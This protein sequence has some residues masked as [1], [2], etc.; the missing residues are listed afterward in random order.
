MA[1]WQKNIHHTKSTT[2]NKS[3]KGEEKTQKRKKMLNEKESF[4]KLYQTSLYKMM[5]KRQQHI[6]THHFMHLSFWILI[7]T[8][9][10]TSNLRNCDFQSVTYYSECA[11]WQDLWVLML[12]FPW[13]IF[14]EKLHID[15]QLKIKKLHRLVFW[16]S[17][18]SCHKPSWSI[19]QPFSKS[20]NKTKFEIN[21][22]FQASII[23]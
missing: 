10:L 4:T 2:W 21:I 16:N 22:Y 12:T 20:D 7:K 8:G 15:I 18:P 5:E 17:K 9:Q 19:F 23:R 3:F 11:M 1:H 6:V 14:L 13:Q